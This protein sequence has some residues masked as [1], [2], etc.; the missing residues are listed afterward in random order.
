[1]RSLPSRVLNLLLDTSEDKLNQ[2]SN[3]SSVPPSKNK[4]QHQH[5]TKKKKSD[6]PQGAQPGHKGSR[7]MLHPH[8]ERMAFTMYKP[9]S[10]CHCGGTVICHK[11]GQITLSL[12]FCLDNTKPLMGE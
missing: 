7:R 3:N 2:S 6:K 4:P 8:N 12:N 1:M 5:Q 10:T 11:K 9:A